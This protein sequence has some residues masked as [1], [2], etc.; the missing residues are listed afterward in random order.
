M[1]RK[2]LLLVFFMCFAAVCGFSSGSKDT[3]NKEDIDK[4]KADIVDLKKTQDD[5]ARTL[6]EL[7]QKLG[8]IAESKQ[9]SNDSARSDE[10]RNSDKFM[11]LTWETALE[12]ENDLDKLDFYISR[13]LNLTAKE[14]NDNFG[15]VKDGKIVDNSEKNLPEE[16]LVISNN[17]PVKIVK[18]SLNPRDKAS[19]D[20][21]FSGQSVWLKFVRNAKD[22]FELDLV[23]KNTKNYSFDEEVL[24]CIYDE[25]SQENRTAVPK[26][27][28]TF[29][30]AVSGISSGNRPQLPEY[31]MLKSGQPYPYLTKDAVVEYLSL[32]S[33]GVT[34]SDIEAIIKHYIKESKTENINHDIAIAQMCYAT[35]L[36]TNK[37]LF[38]N[39]NY[40]GLITEGAVLNGKSWNGKF[41]GSKIGVRAHIQHLKGYASTE[42]LNEKNEDPRFHLLAN[43]RGKGDTLH[44]LCAFWVG[45]NPV[46]YENNLRDMLEDLYR[47]QEKYNKRVLARS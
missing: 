5:T 42:S 40:A 1:Y 13:N 39:N 37:A 6:K 12:F 26:T 2:M 44:K 43:R 19:I 4:M 45:K 47:Y 30:Q 23:T 36:L 16:K 22:Y 33:Q 14:Q 29:K 38:N 31:I 32:N 28:T 46:R 8:N 24:L 34:D 10:R 27:K 35:Q 11:P 18:F 3:G 21:F 9:Q 20:I 7:N 25:R 17:T 15:V 41:P